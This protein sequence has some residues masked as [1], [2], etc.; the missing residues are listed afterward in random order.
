MPGLKE[1]QY[2]QAFNEWAEIE[3]ELTV[4]KARYEAIKKPLKRNKE[5]LELLSPLLSS[6]EEDIVHLTQLWGEKIIKL[7]KAKRE[8]KSV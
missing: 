7:E 5:A 8:L 6:M 1:T 3:R 2:Q 4:T